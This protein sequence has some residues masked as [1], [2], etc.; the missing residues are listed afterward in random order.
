MLLDS[1]LKTVVATRTRT[2]HFRKVYPSKINSTDNKSRSKDTVLVEIVNLHVARNEG[3]EGVFGQFCPDN[4][5]CLSVAALAR[6]R[7]RSFGPQ[8]VLLCCQP[9]FHVSKEEKWGVLGRK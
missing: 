7:D 6:F 9:F 3:F 5:T 8:L 4:S 1:H 2:A